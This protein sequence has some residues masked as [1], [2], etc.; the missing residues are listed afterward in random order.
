MEPPAAL[1]QIKDG[2]CEAWACVQAPQATRTRTRVSALLVLSVHHGKIE[3]LVTRPPIEA[4]TNGPP[5]MLV[6]NGC[7]RHEAEVT[8]I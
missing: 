3:P 6:P 8:C 1:V 4:H 7:L 5:V 2:K